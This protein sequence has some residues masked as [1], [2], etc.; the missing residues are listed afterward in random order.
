MSV[1]NAGVAVAVPAHA[2]DADFG[3]IGWGNDHSGQVTFPAAA[4]SGVTAITAGGSHAVLDQGW[5][6]VLHRVERLW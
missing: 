6:D 1:A 5:C 4:A 2:T 3:A